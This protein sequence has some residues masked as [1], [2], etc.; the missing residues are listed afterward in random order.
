MD[1]GPLKFFQVKLNF[2]ESLIHLFIE[3]K[4]K[5]IFIWAESAGFH[6]E[7][8]RIIIWFVEHMMKLNLG[9]EKKQI[10]QKNNNRCKPGLNNK[11]QLLLSPLKLISRNKNG[12]A[13]PVN[14]SWQPIS[15]SHEQEVALMKRLGQDD[16]KA[17][18]ALIKAYQGDVHAYLRYRLGNEE[19]AKEVA[20][21]VFFQVWRCAGNFQG[22]SKVRY[23]IIG[24]ARNLLNQRLQQRA[25]KAETVS[26]DEIWGADGGAIE[27]G[28]IETGDPNQ[29][30]V[31]LDRERLGLALKELSKE[32]AEALVL[33]FVYG[34]SYKEVAQ[35]QNCGENTAKTRVHYARKNLKRALD[36][37]DLDNREK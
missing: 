7:N 17:F 8:P 37:F 27:F 16:P 5:R 36:Q 34:R 23:W 11:K 9:P 24:I 29:E 6:P 3:R 2:C 28:S 4:L 18:E 13:L 15:T 19:A 35:K 12:K 14:G 1:P 20:N 33:V 31:F 22:K 10:A 21:D 32:Q 26:F 30:S 25:R